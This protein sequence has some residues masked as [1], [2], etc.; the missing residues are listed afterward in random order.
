MRRIR[1]TSAGI[2]PT[3]LSRPA[4]AFAL[5]AAIHVLLIQGIAIPPGTGLPALVTLLHVQ[6]ELAPVPRQHTIRTDMAR[7]R[8]ATGSS[9]EAGATLPSPIS[10]VMMNPGLT[11]PTTAESLPTP[12]TPGAAAAD[13]YLTPANAVA[14]SSS[15]LADPVH[16]AAR[17]LDIF[18]QTK[19]PITPAYPIAAIAARSSGF[20]TMHVLIDEAGRVVRADVVD[21]APYGIFDEAARQ[22][23]TAAAFHPAQKDG[24]VVRSR[25]LVRIE[26]DPASANA[27]R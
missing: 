3:R 15:L 13:G 12:A 8:A 19:S 5:S 24:R 14:V 26:F 23:V 16:Y 1:H 6:L 21:A 22:A 2:S 18:P 4:A 25:V 20:V 7:E 10:P 9:A 27:V 11:L 17:D